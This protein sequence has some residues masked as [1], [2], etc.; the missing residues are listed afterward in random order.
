MNN[1][2]SILGQILHIFS[3]MEFYSI[4]NELKGEEGVTKGFICRE[5]LVPVT[6]LWPFF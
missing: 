1:F 5:Q 2:S 6:V 3:K 4:E